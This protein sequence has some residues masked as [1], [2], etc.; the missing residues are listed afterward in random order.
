MDLSIWEDVPSS[1]RIRETVVCT[2]PNDEHD[3][4]RVTGLRFILDDPANTTRFSGGSYFQTPGLGYTTGNCERT[5]LT[6]RI[7]K[8]RSYQTDGNF[9]TGFGF[10][11]KQGEWNEYY[12]PDCLTS[13]C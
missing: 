12:L 5:T 1:W 9:I 10:K 13:W 11:E 7:K 4:G 2:D 6:E 8:A 3:P